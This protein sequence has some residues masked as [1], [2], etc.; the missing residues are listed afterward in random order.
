MNNRA[1][2]SHLIFRQREQ[3]MNKFE[4]DKSLQKFTSI[5]SQMQN[6]FNGERHLTKRHDYLD[7]RT[8]A[9]SEWRQIIFQNTGHHSPTETISCL[10]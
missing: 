10:A 8:R 9:S 4:S 2:N 7:F 6:H 3:A 5:Q 1:E